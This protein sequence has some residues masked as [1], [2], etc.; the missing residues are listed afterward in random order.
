MGETREGEDEGPYDAEGPRVAAVPGR[1]GDGLS[2]EDEVA[3]LEIDVYSN[4]DGV[5]AKARELSE[6]ARAAGDRSAELRSRLVEADVLARSHDVIA[7]VELVRAV[8]E[9]A[10]TEGDRVVLARCHA[11]MA[12]ALDR[13]GARV[14]S[15]DEA[16]R[17]VQLL[18]D[19]SP[20]HLQ[21]DHTMT[22]A[23]LTSSFR[24]GTVSFD[25]FDRALELAHRLGEPTMQLAVLN[26]MAW[27]RYESGDL[28]AARSTVED[29]LAVAASSG[30]RLNLSTIDTVARVRFEVGDVDAAEALLRAAIDGPDPAPQTDSTALPG[31]L[32]SLAEI[33]AVR[34][35]PGASREPL[36]ACLELASGHR[37]LEMEARALRELSRVHASEGDFE[38]AYRMHVTFYDR[39]EQL[40]AT[41]GEAQAAALQALYDTELAR[42]R[43]REFEQLAQRDPLTGLW[44]R[45]YLSDRL[46]R[47]VRI[48]RRTGRPLS[49]AVADLDHFKRINDELSHEM[50]DRVLVATAQLMRHVVEPTGFV[51]RFG[52]EEFLLVLPGYDRDAAAAV[53]ED[54]CAAMR[55]YPWREDVGTWPV[56]VSIGVSTMGPDGDIGALIAAG[57]THMYQAKREGRDRVATAA[58][59][60]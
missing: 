24:S 6:R 20:L 47:L 36:E 43:S 49:V 18:D 11:I 59:P 27:I 10:A 56:T 16:E 8:Q 23:L 12:N 50:G 17:A 51:V 14:N 1:G 53:A 21:L 60:S 3:R 22:L 34:D 46:P 40:R 19:S 48:A 38:Q 4:L 30:T 37:L 26:N 9:L 5:D 54:V 35:G 44:N 32:L 31:A 25:L 57:D 39:W 55:S 52:G 45:R 42:R 7:A 33:V 58:P 29:L 2:L 13:L 28:D 15:L 41:E